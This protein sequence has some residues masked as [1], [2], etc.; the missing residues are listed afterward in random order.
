MVWCKFAQLSPEAGVMSW[1]GLGRGH[2]TDRQ[3]SQD[4]KVRVFAL[5]LRSFHDTTNSQPKALAPPGTL[6]NVWEPFW[7]TSRRCLASRW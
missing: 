2:P 6:D 3:S 7:F 4:L 1:D 5:G